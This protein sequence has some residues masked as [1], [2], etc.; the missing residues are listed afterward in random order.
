MKLENRINDQI[1]IPRV[2]LI[3]A[4]GRKIG[5]VDN[6]VAR[7]LAEDVGLDLV[8]I[9]PNAKPPV[10]KIMNFGKY[11]YETEKKIKE[12]KQVVIKTKEIQFHPNIQ[13]HDYQHKMN[14]AKEFLE[15]GNKVKACVVYRGREVNYFEKGVEL[16]NKF[17]QDLE[18]LCIVEQNNVFEGK[19]LSIILRKV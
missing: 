13:D 6:Y 12:N 19:V 1:R 16:L 11:C 8:E 4:S 14:Q 15:K 5:I 10:C 9:N 3:D 7:K 17:V 2:Y 18:G